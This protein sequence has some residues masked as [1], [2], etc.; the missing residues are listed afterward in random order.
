MYMY[1]HLKCTEKKKSHHCQPQTHT[2]R[3][4][5][6][7]A[8]PYSWI[9]T[10]TKQLEIKLNIKEKAGHRNIFSSIESD[11]SSSERVPTQ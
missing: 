2:S 1:Q 10:K 7:V 11:G 4:D 9:T 8:S 6:G 3:S 5:Y